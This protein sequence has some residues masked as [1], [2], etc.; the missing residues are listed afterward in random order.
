VLVTVESAGGADAP[1]TSPIVA[2][3]PV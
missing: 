2:S 1:T 3:N